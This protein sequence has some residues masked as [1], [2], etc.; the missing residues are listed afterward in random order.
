MGWENDARAEHE[1]SNGSSEFLEINPIRLGIGDAI[2]L[3]LKTIQ[4]P[5][6]KAFFNDG[7]VLR[8]LGR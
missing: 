7:L 4:A 1:T 5:A 2:T 6:R 8:T 3:S